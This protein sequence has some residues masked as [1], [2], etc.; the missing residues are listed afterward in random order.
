MPTSTLPDS[1]QDKDKLISKNESDELF[2]RVYGDDVARGLK[3]AEETGSAPTTDESARD[4]E[5]SGEG[6]P[7]TYANK[8]TGNPSRSNNSK[9][10][11]ALSFARKRGGIIGL[12]GLLSVGG[13][14][15]AALFAPTGMLINLMENFSLSN[16]TSSTALE[17]RFMKAFGFSTQDGSVVCTGSKIKCDKMDRISNKGLYQLQKKS[18]IV[19]VFGDT[20]YDG[21]RTGYPA[22]QPTHFDLDLGDGKGIQRIPAGSLSQ[23]LVDNPR[24]AAKVLG[25][26]G[27]VN[28]RVKSW[29]GKHITNKFY[30]K[31]D[32]K[33]NGGLADGTNNTGTSA[34][35]RSALLKK[36]V[37][38]IP[39]ASDISG[40]TS[41][42][43]AKVSSQLGKAKKG[44][45]GYVVA[46]ASCI[47][48]KAPMYVAAGVAAVQLAQ[49]L[50][51]VMDVV[52]SPG[53]K[54]KSVA[55]G[56]GF[57]ADDMEGI[58]TLLTEETLDPNTGEY[59]SALDSPILQSAAGINT[60]RPELSSSLTPGL[61]Y[62]TSPLIIASFNASKVTEPACNAIMSPVAM[63]TAMAVDAAV[64]VAAS[65]TII[66]GI[67]KIA[68]SLVISEV[69]AEVVGPILA[70]AAGPT[71][72]ELAKNDAIPNARGEAL[73]DLLG[74]SATGFFSAGGMSRHLPVLTESQVAD[75]AVVKQEN[76][77]FNKEMEIASLSPFDVSSRNTF[78]GSIV[79]NLQMGVM[80]SPNYT[81]GVS[82]ILSSILNLPAFTLSSKTSA[83][84]G[85][86]PNDCSYAKDFGLDTGDPTTTPAINLS[87]LPCPGITS[88][89]ANMPTGQ[90]LDLIADQGWFDEEK[91]ISD[92]ATIEDL[93]SSGYIRE[94]T[95]LYD[96]IQDCSNPET[97]DYIYNS[98]GCTINTEPGTKTVAEL[99]GSVDNV[100]ICEGNGE[101]ITCTPDSNQSIAVNP[102][103][104][105]AIPVF[106][107]DYQVHQIF[108]G[109]D[110]NSTQTSET[111]T[112][113]EEALVTEVEAPIKSNSVASDQPV[114]N[115]SLL[116]YNPSS[117]DCFIDSRNTLDRCL[118]D[119]Q[120]LPYQ[121]LGIA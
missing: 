16:D 24:L 57:T 11:R 38:S 112:A 98:P 3:Q 10:E 62:L 99:N 85:T 35:R 12:I 110:D 88:E 18:G 19:A 49:I 68:G 86:T 31:F 92:D 48:V 81:G 72:V 52:L 29:M 7:S 17:R 42:I 36:L 40:V 73:G 69:A 37:A 63:Y 9:L 84:T 32:I 106:L 87:G 96:Y 13:G 74:I 119:V 45:A 66:G 120:H 117:L 55:I 103:A 79:Y 53:A 111:A 65:A 113:A 118:R 8:V 83:A 20:V 23:T 28:L 34:E 1:D 4:A 6:I 56:S 80:S 33:R 77:D 2:N 59:S 97:G 116:T 50:P 51:V 27:A 30:K 21:T 93:V 76:D 75:F 71:L 108:N 121:I 104:L 47:G 100:P 26:G 61:A 89:Q 115:S 25:T 43:E 95:P 41:N 64:T 54:A 58:G 44:G 5:N 101:D 15:M 91:D 109:E 78:L 105:T 107:L 82:S 114:Y 39:D 102:D 90:A 46:V 22:T 70:N 67:V 94:E 60:G 14:L